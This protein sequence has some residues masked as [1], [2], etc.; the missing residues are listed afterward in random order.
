[1]AVYAEGRFGGELPIYHH[2]MCRASLALCIFSKRHLPVHRAVNKDGEVNA[3]L[4]NFLQRHILP[5]ERIAF[6]NRLRGMLDLALYADAQGEDVGGLRL[7]QKHVDCP[8][9]KRDGQLLWQALHM[10]GFF[11]MPFGIAQ[12]HMHALCV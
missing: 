5:A 12:R 1:M 4:D 11:D 8:V 10:K 9:Q 2:K 7:L 3:A 6:Q